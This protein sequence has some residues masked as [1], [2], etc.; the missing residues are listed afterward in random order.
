MWF[1]SHLGWIVLVLAV[2]GVWSV[3]VHTPP[4]TLATTVPE[5]QRPAAGALPWVS[6]VNARI[7]DDQGRHL[8]LRGFNQDCLVVWP[9]WSPSP[10]DEDDA[11]LSFGGTGAP[12]WAVVP[13]APQ[14]VWQLPNAAWKVSP[15]IFASHAYFWTS[16]DWQTDFELVWRSVAARFRDES[17]LVGY[18]LYNEPVPLPI[19][20]HVF[21][22]QWMWPLYARIIDAI[23]DVDSNH[24]FLVEG[25][26]L[27]D[28]PTTIEHLRAP[29]LVWAP[30]VYT[31]PLTPPDYPRFP[32]RLP[33]AIQD[34]A[35]EAQAIPAAMW[36][37]EL[38]IDLSRSYAVAWTD[39]ALE[40]LDDMQV[41]WA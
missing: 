6:T 26:L 31:G 41:G 19:A 33:R 28:F 2:V 9:A 15:A 11:E 38:G 3:W 13:G 14:I 25:I 32:D 27:W 12:V 8:L 36:A 30:H 29:N 23:P 5:R 39:R 1:L 20:P 24:L 34:D 4:E 35:S 17:G 10:L 22:K 21:E 18:D 7:V 40:T 37:G 16:R